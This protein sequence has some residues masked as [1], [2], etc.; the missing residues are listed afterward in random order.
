MSGD[1]LVNFGIAFVGL[2]GVLV[3]GLINI[4]AQR[5]DRD[6]K[7]EVEFKKLVAEVLTASLAF[8]ANLRQITERSKKQLPQKV[9]DQLVDDLN[10][11][12]RALKEKSILLHM[13]S[14]EPSNEF[15]LA[16]YNVVI[17]ATNYMHPAQG[18][19]LSQKFS[20][21]D[22]HFDRMEVHREALA[23]VARVKPS[24]RQSAAIIQL[25]AIKKFELET[26]NKS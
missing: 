23:A 24:Q 1:S 19:G 16:L 15:A 25:R 22:Y 12:D 20:N 18:S 14:S 6:D 13:T 26:G 21:A 7:K 10:E 4:A 8:D 2:A 9:V 17:D 3:G 11:A 5:V